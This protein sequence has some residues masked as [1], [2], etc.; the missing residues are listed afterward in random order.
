MK[1]KD[2]QQALLEGMRR[3]Q[4]VENAAVASTGKVVDKTSNPIIRLVMEIIQ[5][6]SLM[7]YHVQETIADSLE[8]KTVA[9]SPD[10]LAKVWSLIEKHIEIEKQTIELATQCLAA[11]RGRKMVVQEYLLKYL[12]EDER[13]HDNLLDQLSTIKRGMYP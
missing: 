3:W 5:R 6:D 8:G 9:L 11:L 13:K 4:K 12:L 1:T 2:T 7:H 10:D